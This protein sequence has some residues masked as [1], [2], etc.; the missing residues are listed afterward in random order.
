[1]KTSGY[2]CKK[3]TVALPAINSG[4][5]MMFNRNRMLVFTPLI[6]NSFKALLSF[7][8]ASFTVDEW[9]VTFTSKESKKGEIFTPL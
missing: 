5:L 9:A 1:L 7:R 2:C 4:W 3:F 6:L 8:T